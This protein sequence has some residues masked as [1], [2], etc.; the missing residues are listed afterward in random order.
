[1]PQFPGA[2]LA[3]T[4]VDVYRYT[5]DQFAVNHCVLWGKFASST[6]I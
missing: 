2:L 6:C 4:D 5:I 3:S 1:M